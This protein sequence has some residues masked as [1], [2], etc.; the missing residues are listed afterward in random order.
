MT[1][2]LKI[3]AKT[4]AAEAG[5]IKQQEQ[6]MLR[7]FHGSDFLGGVAR[8]E[9][10]I[11]RSP[12][13]QERIRALHVEGLRDLQE[14]RRGTLRSAARST[15]L[16]RCFLRGRPY[17]QVENR[18]RTKPVANDIWKMVAKYGDISIK[19]EHLDNWLAWPRDK[20]GRALSNEA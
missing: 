3:K 19:R 13:D 4:L 9:D 2:H 17:P 7:G 12:L 8:G 18:H 5:I 16:A 20:D 11:V 10:R 1:I 15:H 6:R 14:H